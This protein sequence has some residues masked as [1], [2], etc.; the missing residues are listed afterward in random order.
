MTARESKLRVPALQL[1]CRLLTVSTTLALVKVAVTVSPA[2]VV[3]V[4]VPFRL[5]T[6]LPPWTLN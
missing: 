5:A 3:P 6:S 1:A 2:L 4:R